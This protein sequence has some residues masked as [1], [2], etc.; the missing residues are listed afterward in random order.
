MLERHEC[1]TI[2]ETAADPL[3]AIEAIGGID[4][5]LA[6]MRAGGPRARK[7]AARYVRLNVRRYPARWADLREGFLMGLQDPDP[8]TRS[9]TLWLVQD[10]GSA[11]ADLIPEIR[12][13]LN[14]D[15][16][17]VRLQAQ[18]ALRRLGANR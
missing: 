10:L 6:V 3:R 13:L 12:A 11:A 16:P 4:A 1:S 18:A 2:G 9:A 14:D 7:A 8:I 15:S 5:V 17:E